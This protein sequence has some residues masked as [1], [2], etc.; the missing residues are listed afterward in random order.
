MA[1]KALLDYLGSAISTTSTHEWGVIGRFD[2][3]IHVSGGPH[4]TTTSMVRQMSLHRRVVDAYSYAGLWIVLSA[5]VILFNKY[6]LTVFRFPFPVALTM[7]HMAFCAALAFTIVRVLK[8]VPSSGLSRE[9]YTKNIVPIA[10]L[11]A[12]SLWTSNTAY[13]H[14]SVAF[15]QMLKSLMPVTVYTLGC[16]LGVEKFSQGRMAN[17][18]I[19]TLGVAISSFGE[20]NFNMFGFR[21][22]IIAIVE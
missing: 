1:L 17:M 22:Q 8:W 3:K 19:I 6:I 12:L 16:V 18:V 13:V 10:G 11:F 9:K 15:I 2:N 4:K 14:L 20:L 7:I 21:V 5:L